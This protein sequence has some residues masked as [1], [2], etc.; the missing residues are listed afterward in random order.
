MNTLF[1]A[2]IARR[3]AIVL[4]LLVSALAASCNSRDS[5]P[6][7]VSQLTFKTLTGQQIVLQEATGPVLVSFWATDCAICI[8]EMPQMA[9]LYEKYES[10]GF[11][12]VAVAMPY[13]AP[14]H[15]LAM[16]ER[17]NWPFPVALD[18]DGEALAAFANVKGTPTS[19][20]LDGQGQLVKRYVGAI[21]LNKLEQQ[22]TTLF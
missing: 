1:D 5:L 12:L 3:S 18:V 14:N 13:D 16:A 10:A 20:L 15:V 2:H 4:V 21:P 8:R 7:A 11:E 6:E 19:Y 17:E 9:A 22:L